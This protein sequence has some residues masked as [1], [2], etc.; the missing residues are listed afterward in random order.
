MTIRKNP[1]IPRTRTAIK[2]DLIEARYDV[3][4][5]EKSLS[6]A[7]YFLAAFIDFKMFYLLISHSPPS[8]SYFKAERVQN[9]RL[10]D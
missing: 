7:N 10:T 8:L 3:D 2:H 5:D 4:L 9:L 1:I 6:D